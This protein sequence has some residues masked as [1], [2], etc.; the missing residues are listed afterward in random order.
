MKKNVQKIWRCDFGPSECGCEGKEGLREDSLII[1][2][3]LKI[4]NYEDTFNL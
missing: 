1:E 2:L 3:P 4:D